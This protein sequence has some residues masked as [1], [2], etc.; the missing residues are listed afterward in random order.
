[1]HIL[2]FPL[3][4]IDFHLATTYTSTDIPASGQQSEVLPV[5]FTVHNKTG[6]IQEF[7]AK[8]GTTDAFM[9]SGNRLV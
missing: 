4:C 5:S 6:L 2:H 7:E 3:V 9:Y 8:M 1:M